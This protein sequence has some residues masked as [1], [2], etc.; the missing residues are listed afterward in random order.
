[1]LTI[2]EVTSTSITVSWRPPQE[3]LEEGSAISYLINV[4]D[5]M[6]N[7]VVHEVNGTILYVRVPELIPD[8]VYQVAVA[9]VLG[10]RVGPSITLF[11]KTNQAVVGMY[12]HQYI[13]TLDITGHYTLNCTVVVS[14]CLYV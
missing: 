9:A 8:H 11:V 1:M 2:L 13:Y 4:T 7:S 14:E 6:G 3:Q 5:T 12:I 10:E